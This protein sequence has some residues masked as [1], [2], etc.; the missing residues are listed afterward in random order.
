MR[1]LCMHC[2]NEK[3]D[4]KRAENN[5]LRMIGYPHN[6]SNRCQDPLKLKA[7]Y[8]TGKKARTGEVLIQTGNRITPLSARVKQSEW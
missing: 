3:T 8:S 5:E 7:K 2:D 4:T 6:S 1:E